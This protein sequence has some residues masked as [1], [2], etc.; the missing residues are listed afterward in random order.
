MVP[1]KKL[2]FKVFSWVELPSNEYLLT[3]NKIIIVV[4]S[5]ALAI[6]KKTVMKVKTDK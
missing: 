2:D 5:I 3:N 1:Q 6:S 4:K